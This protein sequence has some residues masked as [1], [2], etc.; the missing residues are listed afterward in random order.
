MFTKTMVLLDGSP[1]AEQTL[2]LVESLAGAPLREVTLLRVL[3][4]YGPLRPGA[5]VELEECAER[6]RARG[7]S[8]Q[9]SVEEGDPAER[10]LAAAGTERLVIMAT[11][12]RTGVARWALGSVA[13]RVAR[14]GAGAVLLVRSE[15]AS[16]EAGMAASL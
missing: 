5:E 16:P 8:C 4:A 13:D 10:I 1:R 12:G 15:E 3:D 11:H 2:T 6:L 9:W 7:L 14:G